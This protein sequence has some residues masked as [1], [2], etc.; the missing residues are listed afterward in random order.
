LETIVFPL[1]CE[2]V[3][4]L[5]IGGSPGNNLGNLITPE[6]N[7]INIDPREYSGPGVHMKK[8]FTDDD[9]KDYFSGKDFTVMMDIR[10]DR[11]D[12]SNREDWLNAV[13]ND[14]EMMLR[15]SEGFKL[16]KNCLATCIKFRVVKK[17]IRIEGYEMLFQPYIWTKSFETRLY[18]F[19][20]RWFENV[21]VFS[22]SQYKRMVNA[23]NYM[24]EKDSG[25]DLEQ[26]IRIRKMRYFHGDS[27]S[28]KKDVSDYSIGLFNISNVVNDRQKS[29]QYMVKNKGVYFVPSPWFYK[30]CPETKS[31]SNLEN[32]KLEGITKVFDPTNSF[33]PRVGITVVDN[34]EESDYV[35]LPRY[36][37]IQRFL[38]EQDDVKLVDDFYKIMSSDKVISGV[39]DLNYGFTCDMVNGH[40]VVTTSIGSQVFQDHVFS[41]AELLGMSCRIV[42]P[43]WLLGHFG[44]SWD[45]RSHFL[46]RWVVLINDEDDFRE[47]KWQ[48]SIWSQTPLSKNV[49][50]VL[51]RLFSLKD[52]SLHSIRSK[53]LG[54]DGFEVIQSARVNG[55]KKINGRWFYV[56]VAGHMINM[57]LS[58]SYYP[59]DFVRYFDQ[60]ET[61]LITVSGKNTE[62]TK[63]RKE[64]FEEDRRPR[65]WH[66][67][68]DY[69]Y[70]IEVVRSMNANLS[71]NIAESVFNYASSR[72]NSLRKVYK[73]LNKMGFQSLSYSRNPSSY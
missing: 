71:L 23:W 17:I 63:R 16:V 73:V 59:V 2:S 20:K 32:S 55:R 65:L 11:E 72:L 39:G 6:H 35:Y 64:L 44:G 50:L 3:N 7:I 41:V 5:Y 58:M 12:F 37:D 8:F 13:D 43:Q 69:R 48:D 30:W 60:I 31:V 1:I 51:R 25:L 29:M 66:S 34:E 4:L 18:W 68:L 56:A 53:V 46:N 57:M 19:R 62:W 28:M 21:Y 15:W 38:G 10:R 67:Y 27:L 45:S 42:T 54:D 52:S 36:R 61:N 33:S 49:S 24:R 9:V 22:P 40:K 70:A 26:D 47:S 14:T